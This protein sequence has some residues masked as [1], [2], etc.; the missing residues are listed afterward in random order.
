MN[1]LDGAVLRRR[2]HTTDPDEAVAHQQAY[3]R[4]RAGPIERH[5][6]EFSLVTASVETFGVTHMRHA[7]RIEAQA[8]P[9]PALTAVEVVDGEVDVRDARGHQAATDLVLAPTWSPYASR[10]A[11]HLRMTTLDLDEVARVGAEVSG[12][13]PDEVAFGTMTAI[14]PAHARW[15]TTL[16]SHVED[17]LLAHDD[18]MALPLLR[19]EALQ[20]L[21]RAALTVFPNST[22]DHE[23]HGRDSGE[24]ATVRR[25]MAYIDAH[26]DEDVTVT[27]VAEAAR[28]GPR[29]LQA[30]FRRHRGETPLA[31]LRQVRLERAHRD[32]E[33]ADPAGGLTV[34]AIAFRWGFSNPGRF[35]ATYRR[36]YGCSPAE[37]LGR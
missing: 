29:G 17:D 10:W 33:A 37:T 19:R 24:P 18:L 4:F 21:A 22:L 34:A 32:L 26:A 27:E 6:F 16:V 35:S 5:G 3:A 31:Y 25:A 15:W 7:A 1:D 8:E 36:V 14:S 9:T 23:A 28:M 20:R 11:G 2:V 13:A 12:L 30:A